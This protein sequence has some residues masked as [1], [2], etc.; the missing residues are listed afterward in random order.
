MTKKRAP[1][2]KP[3]TEDSAIEKRVYAL[4]AFAQSDHFEEVMACLKEN[5][6]YEFNEAIRE[7]EALNPF[8][9][10]EW[11]PVKAAAIDCRQGLVRTLEREIRKA[12]TWQKR[13]AA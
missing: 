12:K 8:V 10:A 5:S 6:S 11:N 1:K 3:A 9:A 2:A 13:K 4:R 7:F